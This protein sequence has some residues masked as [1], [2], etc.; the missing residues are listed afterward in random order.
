MLRSIM[1]LGK[2]ALFMSTKS[3]M[4]T[5]SGERAT[6]LRSRDGGPGVNLASSGNTSR[7]TGTAHFSRKLDIHLKF[8]FIKLF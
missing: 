7:S 1:V 6:P 2:M 3:A 5:L 4:T 8:L